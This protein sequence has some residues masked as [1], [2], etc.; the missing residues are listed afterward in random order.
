MLISS[1][2]LSHQSGKI[3]TNHYSILSRLQGPD[4]ETGSKLCFES[5]NLL[6]FSDSVCVSVCMFV[7]LVP[8]AAF[9][10]KYLHNY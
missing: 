9:D 2:N 3:A 10:H 1:A 8:I 5:E 6:V 4:C 7:C